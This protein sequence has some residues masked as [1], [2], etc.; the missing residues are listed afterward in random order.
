[1]P[2]LFYI[3]LSLVVSANLEL[4]TNQRIMSIDQSNYIVISPL[5]EDVSVFFSPRHIIMWF[6]RNFDMAFFILIFFRLRRPPFGIILPNLVMWFVWKFTKEKLTDWQSSASVMAF[7]TCHRKHIS[8]RT[9]EYVWQYQL[10]FKNTPN[11]WIWTMTASKKYWSN[12]NL[13]T[14]AALPVP[15]IVSR[16]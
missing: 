1:M 16:R 2:V 3:Y 13:R 4:Q 11:C 8:L 10:L 7:I 12:W 5:S 9:N 6:G 15:A 14:C